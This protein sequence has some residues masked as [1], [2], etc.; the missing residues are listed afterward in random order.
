MAAAAEAQ[1]P[2]FLANF[3]EMDRTLLLCIF[4]SP[5]QRFRLIDQEG[6]DTLESFGDIP[7]D[8]FDCTACTWESKDNRNR[9]SFGIGRLQKLK[10][11]AFW[12]PKCKREGTP[13]AIAD[14]NPDLIQ[15]MS[16]KK[17]YG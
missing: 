13:I 8:T 10:A 6:L 7:D 1:A 15:R 16:K 5:V 3:E 2:A 11:V 14:L 12:V 9:I 17:I 4:T